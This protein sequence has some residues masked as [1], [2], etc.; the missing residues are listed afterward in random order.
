[1]DAGVRISPRA[2]SARRRDEGAAARSWKQRQ[3]RLLPVTFLIRI[4]GAR[5]AGEERFAC[6]ELLFFA[7]AKKSNQKKAPFS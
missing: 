5:L 2:L 4:C 7:G 3:F 6:G 1:M